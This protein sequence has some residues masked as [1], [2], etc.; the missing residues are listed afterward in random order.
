[1]I[2]FFAG[3]HRDGSR[4]KYSVAQEALKQAA[5]S[6]H[7]LDPAAFDEPIWPSRQIPCEAGNRNGSFLS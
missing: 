2:Y 6:Y 1:M 5:R 7:V 4:L 3:P